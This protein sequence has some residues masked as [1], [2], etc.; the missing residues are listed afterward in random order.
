VVA[1]LAG[2]QVAAWSGGLLSVA[3]AIVTC[4]AI[5][6]FWRYQSTTV[7]GP[8]A[9]PVRPASGPDQ[10]AGDAGPAGG[11]TSGPGLTRRS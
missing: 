3:C 6:R 11:G 4:W 7:A 2:P 1:D 5:P 9:R 8:A 10:P